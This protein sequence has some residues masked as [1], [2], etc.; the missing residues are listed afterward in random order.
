MDEPFQVDDKTW[1]YE[2][3]FGGDVVRGFRP[4]YQQAREAMQADQRIGRFFR[5]M[6]EREED[7]E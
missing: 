2:L 1:C 6:R 3:R 4:S 7:W 5:R